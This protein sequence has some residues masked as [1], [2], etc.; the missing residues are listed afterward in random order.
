MSVDKTPWKGEENQR[1][2]KMLADVGSWNQEFDYIKSTLGAQ[3]CAVLQQA[4]A[5][6]NGPCYSALCRYYMLVALFLASSSVINSSSPE[7]VFWS[8]K[9]LFSEQSHSLL[10][11]CPKQKS[12]TFVAGR[13]VPLLRKMEQ[14]LH[15]NAVG[16]SLIPLRYVSVY[17]WKLR[18]NDL[19]ISKTARV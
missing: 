9:A 1:H 15:V 14:Q 16:S 5:R 3:G 2:G 18:L 6:H 8:C 19:I 10:I 4:K 13:K 12:N 11:V 7:A 17:S